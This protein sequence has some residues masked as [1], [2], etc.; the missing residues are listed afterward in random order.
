[1]QKIKA[2]LCREYGA[3]LTIEEVMLRAPQMGE[4]EVTLEAVAICHSDISFWQGGFGGH[5][6]AVYGHE[7]AGRVSALGEGVHGLSIGDPVCVTLIRACGHCDTCGGGHPTICETPYDSVGQ[8]ALSLEDGTPVMQAMASGAFAEKMVVDQSQVVAIPES[9]P[10]GAASL[11]SC[12]VI[13]GVGAAVYASG[14]T[15]GQDVVV[16][17]AGGV[18]LNAIQGARIAGARRIVAVDMLPEKLD[19]AKEFGATDVVSAEGK[20]WS[21]VKKI[22]GRGADAVLVTVGVAQVYDMA[23]RYLA[24][25][26][27]IVMVGMPH[28]DKT[29]SYSPLIMADSGQAIVGSKMGNVVIKRDI[30]WMVD[31]YG[32]GRLKLDELISGTWRLDQINEA[33]ADT[34]TGSAR[35]NVILFK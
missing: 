16:I 18:G 3:P 12:G 11:I 8:S 32:Q 22:L 27:R 9:V 25:G 24:R 15:A 14:I 7:A 21:E 2:A 23:P 13:T 17:G 35:R 29:A 34:L 20:P 6:P 1:M 19:A 30:P 33:I 5:L 4:V 31:L 28:G 26:G 10:M